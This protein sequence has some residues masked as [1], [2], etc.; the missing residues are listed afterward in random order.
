MGSSPCFQRSSEQ[1]QSCFQMA[2]LYRLELSPGNSFRHTAEIKTKR[3]LRLWKIMS[4]DFLTMD[5]F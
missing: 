4:R 3:D 1:L 5:K 2:V